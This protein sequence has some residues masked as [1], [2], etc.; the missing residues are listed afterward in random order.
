MT[1]RPDAK[2][3]IEVARATLASE[4]LP[5]LPPDR[6]LTGLMIA[7]ALAMAAR[8]L[9]VPLPAIPSVTVADIRAG[10]HD[11]DKPLHEALLSDAKARALI[12]NPKD[13]DG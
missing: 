8:E 2:E 10:R 7:S 3:M 12:S 9:E 6:R 1:D 4:V 13:V 5:F 11:A